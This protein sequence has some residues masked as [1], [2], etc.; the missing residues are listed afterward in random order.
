MKVFVASRYGALDSSTTPTTI[1][2]VD[3][4]FRLGLSQVA[5]LGPNAFYDKKEKRFVV[6]WAAAQGNSGDPSRSS[7]LIVCASETDDALGMWT[8]WALRSTLETS[9]NKLCGANW[10]AYD[11]QCEFRIG[12]YT[13]VAQCLARRVC[14]CKQTAIRYTTV[15]QPH[16]PHERCASSSLWS[17]CK[18]LSDI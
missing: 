11:P 15:R 17:I 10:R 18:T 2:F 13:P 7:P 1:P 4:Q 3:I 12:Q 5:A 9:F 6:T 16:I 8:C 14:I